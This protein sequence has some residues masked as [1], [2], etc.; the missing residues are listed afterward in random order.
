MQAG[1]VDVVFDASLMHVSGHC[2]V[3]VL[4][5]N[6]LNCISFL[7]MNQSEDENDG[8]NGKKD[9]MSER[10]RRGRMLAIRSSSSCS[11]GRYQARSRVTIRGTFKLEMLV[12]LQ[13][14]FSFFLISSKQTSGQ[15]IKR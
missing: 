4:A 12:P 11:H 8:I 9:L 15:S 13:W 7:L 14:L 1:L 5:C 3:C 10:V 6:L 2:G